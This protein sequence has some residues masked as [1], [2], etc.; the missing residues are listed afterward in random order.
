M[1][2]VVC[3]VVGG[4]V[5]ARRLSQTHNLT[6]F[7]SDGDL[8]PAMIPEFLR[9]SDKVTSKARCGRPIGRE[10]VHDLTQCGWLPRDHANVRVHV[11]SRSQ[12]TKEKLVVQTQLRSSC[13]SVDP[14]LHA[15]M[16]WY[17]AF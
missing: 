4:R 5:S 10:L 2:R 15:V 7:E 16:N 17:A 6:I 12:I 1:L 3:C 9:V 11:F 13:M 8:K 14:D